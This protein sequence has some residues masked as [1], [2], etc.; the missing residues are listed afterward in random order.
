MSHKRNTTALRRT[1]KE[2]NLCLFS[3]E[4]ICILHHHVPSRAAARILVILK[5]IHVRAEASIDLDDA[6]VSDLQ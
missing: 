1:A 2:S 3:L 5:G 4:T 6:T